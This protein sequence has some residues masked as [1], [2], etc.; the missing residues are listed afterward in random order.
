M[1]LLKK[2]MKSVYMQSSKINLKQILIISPEPWSG[3][4]V[5]K[6]HYAITLASKGYKVYFLNPPNNTLVD[7]EIQNTNY[8]NLFS[9]V[10]PQL[11]KGLR[12]YPKVVRNFIENRWLK[13]LE[14]QIG[15][16]FSTVWLFENSRF[17][18]MNFA[19][20]RLKIYHQVD[21]NQNFHVKEAS[22]SADICF[23]V[24]DF[25]EREL[26][27]YSKKVFK[28]SHGI[29]LLTKYTSLSEEQEDRFDNNSIHVTYIGNLDMLYI[30]EHILYNIT[31]KHSNVIFHYI[32]F[33]W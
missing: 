9:I 14:Q 6:H 12:F 5:S 10:A 30:N 15:S 7:I 1:N 29:N 13:K 16:K 11:T 25:I 2:V 28:I 26:L 22:S 3:Q 27:Q 19:G 23:C 24:T 20:D 17:Y 4:F 21:S 31:R 32:S 33:H 8:K 18:D